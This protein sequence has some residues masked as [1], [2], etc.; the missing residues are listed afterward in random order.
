AFLQRKNGLRGVAEHFYSE[1]MG[2]EGSRS[3]PTAK[4]SFRS[5]NRPF[6][7]CFFYITKDE[8]P[9]WND[10]GRMKNER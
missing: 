2:C 1:K 6:R 8:S 10:E 7:V 4:F 5:F 9:K 3:I